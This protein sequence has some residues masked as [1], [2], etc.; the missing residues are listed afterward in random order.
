LIR[1]TRTLQEVI[2]EESGFEGIQTAH[3]VLGEGDAFGGI[4]A[5]GS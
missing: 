3:G 1:V 5:P 4:P 2:G